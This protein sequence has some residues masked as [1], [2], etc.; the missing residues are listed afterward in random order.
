MSIRPNP[1]GQDRYI[2]WGHLGN[3]RKYKNVAAKDDEKTIEERKQEIFQRLKPYNSEEYVY[4]AAFVVGGGGVYD[5][6]P[7]PT[8]SITP[9]PVTPTPTPSITPTQTITPTISLT[10][11]ITPT[12][13]LTPTPTPTPSQEA[14]GTT[15]ARTYLSAVVNAGGTGITSGVSAATISLFTSLV[16]NGLYDK[17]EAFYPA[18]GGVSASNKFNAKNPV[19]SDAAYRLTFNGGWTHTSSGATPNGAN[20]YANTHLSGTTLDRYSVHTSYYSQIISNTNSIDMGSTQGA[21]GTSTNIELAINTAAFG[22]N[23]RSFANN[24]VGP[25]TNTTANTA[26]TGYFVSSRV[27]DSQS[28]IY[29]DGVFDA[30]GT[31][32]TNGHTPYEIYIGA[33]NDNGNPTSYSAKPFGF[34][35]I[36]DGLTPAEISTLSSIVNT[37]ATSIGRNTY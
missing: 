1:A 19:D 16:S 24:S 15:E 10:P 3:F 2:S 13:T 21:G 11:T 14:S 37:W 34:V 4:K 7:T 5:T 22:G 27:N 33:R 26:T 23:Y 29:K 32:A 20:A 9:S 25:S 36:G 30:S 28:Y 8:P 35:S 17:M 12:S 6:T 31:T 18:L